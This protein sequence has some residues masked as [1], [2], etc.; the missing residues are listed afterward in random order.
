MIFIITGAPGAGKGTISK[1]VEEDL[2]LI[3]VSTGDILRAQIKK[4]DEFGLEIKALID[5][6]NFVIL[7]ERWKGEE[8]EALGYNQALKH[9]A[10]VEEQGYSYQVFNMIHGG[11]DAKGRSKIAGIDPILRSAV[12]RKEGE[13]WIATVL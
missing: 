6:G 9:I 2:G 3:H 13:D 12:V 5:E 11:H 4:G 8:R 10:L 1:I 7:C